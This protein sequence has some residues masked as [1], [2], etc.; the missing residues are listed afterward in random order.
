MSNLNFETHDES[1]DIFFLNLDEPLADEEPSNSALG[2]TMLNL[3][4]AHDE[5]DLSFSFQ[6]KSEEQSEI[7]AQQDL[8]NQVLKDIKAAEI[9]LGLE[10]AN[11]QAIQMRKMFEQKQIEFL[12]GKV[13]QKD[14]IDEGNIIARIGDTITPDLIQEAKAQ[15]R[16]I[17]LIMNCK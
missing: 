16:L 8:I 14:I 17:E 7:D 12:S 6:D 15:G 10:E 13:V 3:N 5:V 1:E 9:G 2:E 4:E 11:D